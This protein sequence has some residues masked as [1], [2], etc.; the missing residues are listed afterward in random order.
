MKKITS[1]LLL[2]AMLLCSLSLFACHKKVAMNSLQIPNE[3]DE[4]KQYEITFW[5]KNE[6]NATQREVYAKAVEDFQK[7]YPNL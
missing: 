7:L 3:F 4:S 5:A 6:N 2:L 1:L